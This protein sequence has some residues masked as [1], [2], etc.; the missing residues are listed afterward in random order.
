VALLPVS[1]TQR[2]SSHFLINPAF[3]KLEIYHG[4]LYINQ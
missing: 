3:I 2:V 1:L 4:I